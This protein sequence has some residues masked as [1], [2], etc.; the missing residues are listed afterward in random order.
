MAVMS[1]SMWIFGIFSVCK[2]KAGAGNDRQ[3]VSRIAMRLF[4]MAVKSYQ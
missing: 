4:D 2:W 3:W 1:I